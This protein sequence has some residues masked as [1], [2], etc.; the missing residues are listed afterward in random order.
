[1]GIIT[2]DLCIAYY[3]YFTTV[4]L[5]NTY[6]NSN[7]FFDGNGREFYSEIQFSSEV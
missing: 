6:L 2:L 3:S 7:L 4:I 5:I 1:M